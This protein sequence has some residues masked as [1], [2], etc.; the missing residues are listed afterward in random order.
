M[1]IEYISFKLRWIEWRT[2][3]NS[4]QLYNKYIINFIDTSVSMRKIKNQISVR[5]KQV[6]EREMNTIAV[7][8][9]VLRNAAYWCKHARCSIQTR[10]QWYII[11]YVA[12]HYMGTLLRIYIR[13]YSSNVTYPG[14]LNVFLINLSI[15]LVRRMNII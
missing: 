8:M 11:A 2:I 5:N 7:P 14:S 4:M 10:L 1:F 3:L 6:S 13:N 12:L 9:Y 15:S